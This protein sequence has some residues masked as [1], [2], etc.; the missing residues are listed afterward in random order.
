MSAKRWVVSALSLTTILFGVSCGGGADTASV[1][2]QALQGSSAGVS[3]AFQPV[4]PQSVSVNATAQLTA[5]VKNDSANLGVDWYLTCQL[6]GNCGS[7]TPLHTASGS[8]V[9]YT[10]PPGFSG[11]TQSVT[12]FAFATA[13]HSKNLLTTMTAVAFGSALKGKYVLQTN[14]V[15][16]TG[17]PYQFAAVAVLDGNGGVTSG[18]QTYNNVTSSVTNAITGGTYFIGADGRGKLTLST[19]NPSIGQQGVETFSLV[20][21]SSSQALIAKIDDP[22]LSGVSDESSQGTMDLQTS[23]APPAQGY[24]FVVTGDDVALAAPTSVGGVFNIDSPNT[25]SGAGSVADQDLDASVTYSS[26]LSGTVSNP[27]TFGAVKLSLTAN[28]Y[29]TPMQF[30]GYIVDGAHMKLIETDNNGTAGAWTSGVAIGQGTATGTFTGSKALS[31]T[32][33]FGVSGEDITGL[34]SSLESAG[35]FSSNGQG[36]LLS[37]YDDEYLSGEGQQI[38]DRFHGK[39]SV[40][41]SGTGRVDSF[42]T[43]NT[44]GPGPEF[45]LYLTGNGNSA[46]LLDA[47][48]SNYPAIGGGLLY[49]AASQFSFSGEYGLR[50]IQNNGGAEDDATG[51][52]KVNSEAQTLSAIVDTNYTFIPA[53]DTPLTGTFQNNGLHRFPGI[54]SNQFFP[55][56]LTMAFYIIDADHGLF[57]END[58]GELTLGYF[59]TRTP[60]CKGCP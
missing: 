19:K 1:K 39:Y 16:S 10:P 36:Y 56:N 51:Q 47:D 5:V 46:L 33:V 6:T 8:P 20:V 9:T 52:M 3:I 18:E 57:V 11:N 4:P 44:Y 13:D 43:F 2:N 24:A 37:G 45:I 50:F 38:S 7:I 54:L 15:D 26:P 35:V 14:G 31:G 17:Y 55:Q 58:S 27:D 42:I 30:T 48:N 29:S 34:A 49:P 28:F 41:P 60:V 21:L 25:V 59:A 22:N 32:F 23:V 12:I 40:D 53:W